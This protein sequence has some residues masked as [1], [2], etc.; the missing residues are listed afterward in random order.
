MIHTPEQARWKTVIACLE[1]GEGE[2]RLVVA[3]SVKAAVR[4]PLST[5][6]AA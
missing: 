1:N 6:R 5:R 4:Q 3:S 2:F